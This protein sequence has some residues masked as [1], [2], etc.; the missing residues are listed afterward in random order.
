M[1]MAPLGDLPL[2]PDEIALEDIEASAIVDEE[3]PS[4]DEELAA[5]PPAVVS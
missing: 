3:L 4:D 5:P 1:A 2:D